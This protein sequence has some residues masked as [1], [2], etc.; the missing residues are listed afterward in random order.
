Q[1]AILSILGDATLELGDIDGA[2]AMYARV[3][4]A[5]ASPAITARLARLSFLH[6]AT[7]DAVAQAEAAFAAAKD[8]GTTGPSLSWYAYLAGTMTL[9][10]GAP[11]DAATWFDQA[12][13][14]WPGSYLALAG[15]ARAAAAL[16]D[17]D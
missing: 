8:A 13:D 16:G 10:T 9:A 6:G 4:S 11:S 5:A 7:A 14:A 17:V 1:P 3:A 15:R 12:L 2:A